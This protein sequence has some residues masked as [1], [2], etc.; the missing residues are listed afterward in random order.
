MVEGRKEKLLAIA[1][2]GGTFVVSTIF[3]RYYGKKE[4]A[5]A[6]VPSRMATLIVACIFAA[7][8][9]LGTVLAIVAIVSTQIV[10]A[11]SFGVTAFGM[12]G[13]AVFNLRLFQEPK[14]ANQSVQPTSITRRG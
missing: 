8:G 10:S 9:L 12:F 5:G 13:Y 7:L 3:A 14:M 11:I 6:L 4:S 2:T 1:L